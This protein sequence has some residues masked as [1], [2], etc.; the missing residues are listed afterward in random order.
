ML[1]GALYGVDEKR[2]T[3]QTAREMKKAIDALQG[4]ISCA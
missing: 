2:V 1:Q 4:D 3:I